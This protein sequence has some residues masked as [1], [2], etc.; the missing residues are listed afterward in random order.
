[1]K[2]KH[3]TMK[4]FHQIHGD[5]PPPSHL[6]MQM[7]EYAY[8]IECIHD[9]LTHLFTHLSLPPFTATHI[10]IY[11]PTHSCIHLSFHPFIQLVISSSWS[12]NTQSNPHLKSKGLFGSLFWRLWSK[13]GQNHCFCACEHIMVEAQSRV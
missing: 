7:E 8:Q 4:F 2:D 9:S 5:P 11:T 3:F 12:H 1:M 10:S 13:D 6:N